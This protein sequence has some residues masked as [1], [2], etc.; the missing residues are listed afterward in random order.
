MSKSGYAIASSVDPKVI[1]DRCVIRLANTQMN[2]SLEEWGEISNA[3]L[4]V[5]VA[6]RA[7][8][9]KLQDALERIQM[10][11]DLYDEIADQLEAALA[12]VEKLTLRHD[13]L[14]T[15]HGDAWS[16]LARIRGT[17]DRLGP[18]GCLPLY[19]AGTS[20]RDEGAALSAG[21]EKIATTAESDLAATKAKLEA[22]EAAVTRIGE[23]FDEADFDAAI[24]VALALVAIN[25]PG[26]R[27]TL[28]EATALTTK[29]APDATR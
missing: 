6:H 5:S 2:M 25:E 14:T 4:G 24:D 22:L 28:D 11:K 10:S 1:I 21:I 29:E 23:T 7:T 19:E 12:E 13:V 15:K 3:L 20:A 26:P 18:V 8:E 16:A 17:I 27:L 9:A